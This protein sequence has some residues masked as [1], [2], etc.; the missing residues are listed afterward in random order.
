MRAFQLKSQT[1]I[2][3]LSKVEIAEPKPARGQ[4]AVRVSACSLNFR[5]LSIA[6][7]RYRQPTRSSVIPLS[8]GAGEVIAV[9]ADVTR[10]KVGDRVAGC[11]FQNWVGGE[12]G[13]DAQ[14]S[15]LG[16]GVDGM[17][18]EVVVLEQEGVVLIPAHMSLAEAATLPCAALTAWHAL[19]EH[20]RLT[21]GQT[22]LVQG[23][24]GVSIFALQIAHMMGVEVIVTS[25]S[26]EKLARAKA[27]GA[28]H[29]INY[30]TTPDWDK[31]AIEITG[32]RGVDQV[33][34]VGGPGTFA[35][36][37]NA[38]RSGGKISAIGVL[39]GM[40]EI[41]PGMILAKRVNAQGI[42][43]GSTRMFEAMNRAF[44]FNKLQP[45]VD[46]TFPFDATQ[47]AYR[48]LAAGAHFGKIV[49]SI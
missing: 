32:G 46:T 3:A 29:L 34:E 39:S 8:D 33:V 28:T 18:A 11:F 17:L 4:V 42:S 7:G 43:V 22:I 14:A 48:H 27:L 36:S 45:I 23:T 9:G 1:G 44:A 5:D 15:A 35:K 6:T 37:L 21:P 24:G 40:A 38:I 13:A 20:G 41:N 12:P 49:I 19:I 47:D 10:V 25:S 2:E 26:D 16:G 30:K 31:A